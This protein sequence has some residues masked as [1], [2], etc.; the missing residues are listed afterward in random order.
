M[1]D[2]LIFCTV[3]L[4][5]VALGFLIA[6]RFASLVLADQPFV[7]ATTVTIAVGMSLACLGWAV[8]LVVLS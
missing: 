7:R 4:A 8:A 2:T 3:G 1:S 5:F 6:A